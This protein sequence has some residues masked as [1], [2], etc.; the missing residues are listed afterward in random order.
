MTILS[1]FTA[2]TP[3]ELRA[4]SFGTA[5]PGNTLKVVDPLTGLVV[6]RRTRGEICIKGP[7]L[8]LGYHAKAPEQTFDEDGYYHTG[9]GG[10]VDDAG[11]LYWEGRLNYIIKTGGANVSPE[12]VDAAIASCPGV[13][14]TQTVGL[15]HETLSEMVV[16]CIVPIDGR[17]LDEDQVLAHLKQRLASFKLPRKVLFCADAEFT[18]TGNEKVRVDGIRQLAAK[19]LGIALADS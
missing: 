11:R 19:R 17:A 1:A 3:A 9:D 13:R 10:Y 4:G 7:T 15:P 16:S 14:R 6:P 5:L 2:D 8:M 12:E 18:L